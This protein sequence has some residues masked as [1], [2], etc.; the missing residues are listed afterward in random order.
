[1][2]A[3]LRELR[4]DVGGREIG[5]L[6]AVEPVDR[7]AIFP[8][9]ARLH[10]RQPGTGE[11][12]LRLLLEPALGGHRKDQLAVHRALPMSSASSRSIQQA[13]PTAGT[14]SGAPSRASM[15]S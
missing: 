5:H 3:A 2:R 4:G 8:R 1:M 15:P 10:Q 7:A 13:K 11:E 9:A 6:D 12:I 14:C